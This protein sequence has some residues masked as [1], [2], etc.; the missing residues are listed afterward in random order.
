M[1]RPAGLAW[2]GGAVRWGVARSGVGARSGGV[3]RGPVW[4]RGLV[5]VWSGLA[6]ISAMAEP[7]ESPSPQRYA[8]DLGLEWGWTWGWSGAGVLARKPCSNLCVARHDVAGEGAAGGGGGWRG[9]GCP[10][11]DL[12]SAKASADM[13]STSGPAADLL[14]LAA[15]RAHVKQACC[16]LKARH[17]ELLLQRSALEVEMC[18]LELEAIELQMQACSMTGCADEAPEQVEEAEEAEEEDEAEEEAGEEEAGEE[19]EEGAGDEDEDEDGDEEG[20]EDDAGG[21]TVSML[22]GLLGWLRGLGISVWHFKFSGRLDLGCSSLEAAKLQR[23]AI[24]RAAAAAAGGRV[25]GGR[26]GT[27]S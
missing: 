20:D 17:T 19:E 27:A 24:K 15:R 11:A 4:G 18:E 10:L 22:R 5:W 9:C 13:G 26:E 16:V 14:Q 7:P 6:R 8:A 2:S 23:A 12:W 21:E 25:E 1:G 3:W